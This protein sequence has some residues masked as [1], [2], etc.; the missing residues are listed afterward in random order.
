MRNPFVWFNLAG[1]GEAI[2]LDTLRSMSSRLTF[3][4]CSTSRCSTL[5]RSGPR[6]EGGGVGVRRKRG[7]YRRGRSTDPHAHPWTFFS[8]AP[9]GGRGWRRDETNDCAHRWPSTSGHTGDHSG[10]GAEPNYTGSIPE[11]NSELYKRRGRF[12][13]AA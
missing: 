9:P 10:F 3:E 6:I 4:K 5:S 1:T 8:A 2:R 7:S 13:R 12:T 11:G